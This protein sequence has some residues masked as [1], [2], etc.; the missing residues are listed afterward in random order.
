[1][2]GQ[3][4]ELSMRE[5][6]HQWESPSDATSIDR[7]R[8][9][10]RIKASQYNL[11]ERGYPRPPLPPASRATQPGVS[12]ISNIRSYKRNEPQ[13][14]SSEEPRNWDSTSHAYHDH[15]SREPVK[16]GYIRYPQPT[17]IQFRR[18]PVDLTGF[19][20]GRGHWATRTGGLADVWKCVRYKGREN[21]QWEPVA[22]K[23]F[24]LPVYDL[25]Q[26]EI[27]EIIY[28]IGSELQGWVRLPHHDHVL[29]VYGMVHGFGPLPSLVY[30]WVEN[31]TL[32]S[33]LGHNPKLPYDRRLL[34]IFQV[35]SGLQHRMLPD[36][37]FTSVI[38]HCLVH[39]NHIY[40]GDLTGSSILVDRKGNA[41]IADF[42]ISSIMSQIRRS[43]Y[44]RSR[45]PGAVRWMDPE[46]LNAE[47]DMQNSCS[48]PGDAD[49]KNDIY[50][51]GCIM[52]QKFEHLQVLTGLPPYYGMSD[53]AVQLAKLRGEK[54]R[55]PIGASTRLVNLMEGCWDS[56]RR[57]RPRP[58]EI[59]GAIQ[60]ELRLFE[61]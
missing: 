41:L 7:E 21:S 51:M 9:Q 46:L 18:D 8:S 10:Q 17:N 31:G 50:S 53:T 43:A 4:Q 3:Q 11:D 38:S 52:L 26:Q 19:I 13:Q 60:N 36:F 28:T 56:N 6:H 1:M 29:A 57:V 44:F 49:P 14:Q 54:P 12:S 33:Y 22:V 45:K 16:D 35:A 48:S 15:A 42:G 37:L 23:C 27:D 61:V 5:S 58:G 39:I 25:C 40:H 32:T 47:Q 2:H 20:H 30:P 24:R 59:K 34:M 55:V